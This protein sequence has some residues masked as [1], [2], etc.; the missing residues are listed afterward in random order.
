[1]TVE[2]EV[3]HKV[4]GDAL[5]L[6]QVLVNLVGNAV[7]FT[8]AGRVAVAVSQHSPGMFKFSVS[9][10]GIGISPEDHSAIFAPFQ[11][12]DGS[13]TRRFG[14]TGLGLSVSKKLAGLMG[15]E[16][17]VESS[18]SHGSTFWF[19]ACFEE[20]EALA[21]QPPVGG[22]EDTAPVG[23]LRILL[24]EDNR[25]NQL[26]ALRLLESHGHTVC[27]AEDGRA[28][29]AAAEAGAFDV[30]LMDIQM[31]RMDGLEATAAIRQRE[32]LSGTRVPIVAL[33]AHA[34][35]GDRQRF[36]A[37]G[38]DGYV[39][40]PIRIPELL[41]A[42]AQVR[43]LQNALAPSTAPRGD[44]REGTDCASVRTQGLKRLAERLAA[45][46]REDPHLTS[47]YSDVRR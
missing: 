1:M 20:I 21:S 45:S 15:G 38:M 47:D 46:S 25:V 10:T 23:P 36:L 41:A 17:G 34:M 7:K 24:A 42:I 22:S 18:P 5:R 30:I 40:K 31:P 43:S 27:T 2:D 35:N 12:A 14:G 6:R 9:D 39:S 26:V 13:T 28:A 4:V 8:Q 3:P 33:T 29:V 11:Q 37:A 19:T 16:I 32:R 44:A